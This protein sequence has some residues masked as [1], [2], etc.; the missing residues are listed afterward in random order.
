MLD[1]E[2]QY[3]AIRQELLLA[4]TDV[5]DCRMVILGDAGADP[6]PAQDGCVARMTYWRERAADGGRRHRGFSEE[7]IFQ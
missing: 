6:Y 5:I 4:L 2:K 3:R 1:L 7:S